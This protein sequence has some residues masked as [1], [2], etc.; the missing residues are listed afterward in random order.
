VGVHRIGE[1]GAQIAAGH[2]QDRGRAIELGVEQLGIAD[3][4]DDEP[5]ARGQCPGEVVATARAEV[6]DR[7]DVDPDRHQPVDDVA[8]DEAGAPCDD[9]ALAS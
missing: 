5:R 7:D 6:V 1:R 2:V 3:V 8:A 4:A 9:D